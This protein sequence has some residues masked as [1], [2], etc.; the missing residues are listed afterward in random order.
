VQVVAGG[1]DPGYHRLSLLRLECR[2]RISHFHQQLRRFPDRQGAGEGRR[3]ASLSL[4]LAILGSPV[5]HSLSPVIQ[6]AAL[7]FAG[8]EGTYERRDVDEAGVA[9][10]VEEITQGDLADVVVEAAG[11]PETANMI[12]PLL[13]LHG[14]AALFGLP[15]DE[16]TFP[17]DYNAMMSKLPTIVA[18]IGARSGNP[19][20][21]IKECVDLVAQG[22]LDLS[23][24]VTHRMTLDDVQKA[25]DM[26]SEKTDGIIKVIMDI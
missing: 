8:I 25:Y 4:R 26:Y 23:H 21:H 16:D 7:D 24:L 19:T 15:H 18:T 17:F 6:R 22:R 14:I 2:R 1:F 9:A 20:Q 11:R 12:W 3:I 13:R 5:S 10:A